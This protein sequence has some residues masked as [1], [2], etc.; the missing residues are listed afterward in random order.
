MMQILRKLLDHSS[1]G[2]MFLS[3][4]EGTDTYGTIT[5]ISS[6]VQIRGANIWIL[7]CAAGLASIGLDVDSVAVIIGAM[8]ISPL[9]AP[10]LGI[11]LGVGINDRVLLVDSVKNFAIAAGVSLGASAFYFLLTPLGEPTPEL[12]ARIEP[13][14]LDVGVALFGGVAGIIAGSRRERANVLPGVAIA[15]ALMPPLCTAGF[16][17]ATGRWE[18]FFGAFYLF[19]INA[20]FISFAT[21]V[22]VRLLRFPYHQFPDKRTKQLAQR[23]IIGFAIVVT[24]PSAFIFYNVIRDLRDRSA[25]N[26]FLSDH[27][28]TETYEAIRSELQEEGDS[29]LYLKVYMVGAPIDQ[30]RLDSI[31]GLLPEYGLEE[32]RLKVFQINI[33]EQER[34]RLAQEATQSVLKT[35]EMSQRAQETGLE[36]IDSLR[37]VIQE[38]EADT[39]PIWEIAAELSVLLPEVEEI[40][41][42]KEVQVAGDTTAP[43]PIFFYDFTRSY[44]P[45]RQRMVRD[46]LYEFL[47]RR[48]ELD[49]LLLR[50]LVE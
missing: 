28:K 4:R 39:I 49:T 12:T 34:K 26:N 38:R 5:G 14:L 24:A 32:Y 37:Q 23:W 43:L 48:V 47:L 25:V 2:G 29:V 19:F 20:F 1:F 36:T 40:A 6:N 46:R 13:T 21:F 7:I 30:R 44:G 11:G 18:F 50:R 41:Y 10:I 27:M 8:L 3:L 42:T 9:M 35:I 15:T 31:A 17:I 45:A 33:P 22:I 16:G